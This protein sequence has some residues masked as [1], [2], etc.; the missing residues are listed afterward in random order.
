MAS[1]KDEMKAFKEFEKAFP[2]RVKSLSFDLCSWNKPSYK[3]YLAAQGDEPY[4]INEAD[5]PEDAVNK[6]ILYRKEALE[7]KM[8]A[9]QGA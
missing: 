6:L 5:H 2:G 3:A 1:K 8:K 4:Y 9:T 7:S